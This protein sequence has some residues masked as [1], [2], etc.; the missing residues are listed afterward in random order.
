MKFFLI[1]TLVILSQGLLAQ[2]EISLFNSDGDPIAYIDS[3]DNDLTIYL[4]GGNPVAYLHKK[5]GKFHV[6]GFNGSHLGWFIDG[7]IR[8]HEGDAV[9][10]TK[11][12]TDMYTQYEPYKAYKQYKPYKSYKEYAPYQPY[13]SSS[14]SSMNFKL[15][16]LRG[17]DD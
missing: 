1:S 2:S 16:L 3:D 8:D 17:I 5:S 9:G 7:I 11:N 13:L 10:A 14:W 4:W 15:F 12:A 6:Y